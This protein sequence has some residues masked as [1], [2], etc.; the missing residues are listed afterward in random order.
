MQ[1][2]NID[3]LDFNNPKPF[4]RKLWTIRLF[5]AGGILIVL[6]FLFAS[7]WE[8]LG[9]SSSSLILLALCQI[10]SFGINIAGLI[11]GFVEK[12]KNPKW[13]VIGI[14]GNLILILFFISIIAYAMS[15][16]PEM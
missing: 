3:L 6:T 1:Q 10:L 9:L 2:D 14:I 16:M 5:I 15:V 4:A 13:A 8:A 12:K 11:F 7:F